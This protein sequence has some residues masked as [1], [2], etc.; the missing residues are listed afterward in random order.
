MCSLCYEEVLTKNSNT[1]NLYSHLKYKHPTEYLEVKPQ[2]KRLSSTSSDISSSTSQVSIV[3]AF[4]KCKVLST[5]SKEHKELTDAVTHCLGKDGLPIYTVER[6]GFVEMLHRFNPRYCLPSCHHFSRVAIPTLYIATKERILVE[7]DCNME[8]FLATTD[9][10]SSATM[11]P[12][13]SYSIHFID[14]SWVLKSYCLQTH[15]I[16]EDHTGVNIKDHLIE[17]LARWRLNPEKQ[18]AMTTDNGANVKLTCEL[19][20]WNRLSCFRH[21]LDLSVKRDLKILGL[22]EF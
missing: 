18:V 6:K 16:P 20:H 7:L 5:T 1:S 14:Q 8:F 3:D 4:E 2:F 9:L 22:L 12:Y 10:W 13:I 21:N 19:L 17:S 15:F 11:Q